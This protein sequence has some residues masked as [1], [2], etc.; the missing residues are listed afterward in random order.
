VFSGALL[1]QNRG[2]VGGV[3]ATSLART[4]AF[5][6][7]LTDDGVALYSRGRFLVLTAF[8]GAAMAGGIRADSATAAGTAVPSAAQDRQILNFALLLEDLKSG[9]YGEALARGTLRGETRQFA[10]V[11]GAHERA[12]AK[13]LRQSLGSHARPRATFRFGALTRNPGR[14][15]AAATELEELA[16]GAYNGQAANLTKN[17]LAA[18]LKIVSVEGRHA[19]W[20]RAIADEEPAPS[21]ADPGVDVA[22]VEAALKKLQIR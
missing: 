11:A 8:V 12:H 20:I 1:W 18:A 13:L 4:D 16:V 3:A 21:A 14:F 5:D 19:A 9:F 15:V 22:A 6:V 10:E 2:F 17:A 7:E